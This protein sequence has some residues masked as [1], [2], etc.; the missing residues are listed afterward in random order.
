MTSRTMLYWTFWSVFKDLVP[1][2][3]PN[4]LLHG[5]N[6]LMQA[7]SS[8][9]SPTHCRN[10][11]SSAMGYTN[12]TWESESPWS[13]SFIEGIE[14]SS[15][16]KLWINDTFQPLDLGSPNITIKYCLAEPME[17]SCHV[18]ISLILFLA[19]T[20]CVIAKTIV[21]IVVTLVLSRRGQTPLVTLGDAIASFIENPDTVTFGL[22]T[23][24]QAGFLK[25]LL[26]SRGYIVPGPRK[27][28]PRGKRRG[29]AVPVFVWIISYTLFIISIGIT[30]FFFAQAASGG[31]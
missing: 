19:V 23:L 29:S 3:L 22:C 8:A 18:G 4:H 6:C 5:T 14:E 11:C 26:P 2:E 30:V 20:I 17:E 21:A 25:A 10:T 9:S 1:A 12:I 28:Q 16:Y 24:D 27:W 31:M 13:Y 15:V 7:A